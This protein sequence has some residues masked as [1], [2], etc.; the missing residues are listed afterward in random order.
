M[1]ERRDDPVKATKLARECL[2]C[3]CTFYPTP[4]E[5][6]R[7]YGKYCS[8]DCF[9]KSRR[10]ESDRKESSVISHEYFLGSFV[11]ENSRYRVLLSECDVDLVLDYPGGWY[12][13][14]SVNT[15]GRARHYLRT[16][17]EMIMLHVMLMS[18][19]D[20][21][22][23]DHING[24]S[25]DNRRENLRVVSPRDNCKNNRGNPDSTSRF[26][27]VW[28]HRR[29]HKWI[30][31]IKDH[32]CRK[33]YL[34]S[35]LEEEDAALIRDAAAYRLHGEMAHLNFPDIVIHGKY[36]SDRIQQRIDRARARSGMR[37]V[38]P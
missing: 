33:L 16:S 8:R 22:T 30:A 18:R 24:N 38:T 3:L 10:R 19:P 28:W 35:F 12:L 5:V 23:V 11:V 25:L 27:G 6:N 29:N 9:V 2:V 32:D 1:I 37:E 4:F 15:S 17:K 7:G 13:R 34:G 20:G 21:M 26:V 36:F 31:E 14:K